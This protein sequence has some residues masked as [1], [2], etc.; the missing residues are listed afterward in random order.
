MMSLLPPVAAK[1]QSCVHLEPSIG[2][3]FLENVRDIDDKRFYRVCRLVC[4]NWERR[5]PF[6]HPER[7]NLRVRD[8]TVWYETEG[9]WRLVPNAYWAWTCQD[10]EW[11][12]ERCCLG[13]F[14]CKFDCTCIRWYPT[15]SVLNFS[16][17]F[18]E[19]PCSI[20]DTTCP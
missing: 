16:V 13:R 17:A 5:Y 3:R 15:V 14:V 4:R 8:G 1:Q 20:V 6:G 11:W 18:T 2:S 9:V 10:V 19:R 7:S 12:A